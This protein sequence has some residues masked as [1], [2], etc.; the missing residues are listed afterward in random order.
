MFISHYFLDMQGNNSTHKKKSEA[1][2]IPR[3]HNSM[4]FPQFA[5]FTINH[6]L[7]K[8][9]TRFFPLKIMFI[10]MAPFTR[11]VKEI[12]EQKNVRTHTHSLTQQGPDESKEDWV[13]NFGEQIGS[14]TTLPLRQSFTKLNPLPLPGGQT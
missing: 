13:S 4:K 3:I 2:G 7:V 11:L 10:N 6:H 8:N 14:R 1:F 12:K 5:M 9:W